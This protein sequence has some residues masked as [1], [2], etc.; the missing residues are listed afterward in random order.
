[1]K[2]IIFT[3]LSFLL[4]SS[5]TYA[6]KGIN[7]NRSYAGG[8][9][10]L[11]FLD[12]TAKNVYYGT[13]F[14]NLDNTSFS[15]L[16]GE[17]SVSINTYFRKNDRVEDYRYTILIDNTPLTVNKSIDIKELK[18]VDHAGEILR[19]TS[20][21]DFVI[22]GTAITVLIYSINNPLNIQKSVFYGKQFP[23]AKIT[24]FLKN[25]TTDKGF[26][27]SWIFDPEE[28]SD[29][30][31]TEKDLDLTL[32]KDKTDIDYLYSTS[33][34]DKQTNKIIFESTAWNYSIISEDE[35]ALLASVKIDKNVFR[36]SGDYEI[37][38]Q[39]LMNWKHCWEC[40]ISAKEIESYISRYT[41]SVTLEN[42][43]YS[44]KE[45]WTYVGL[46]CSILGILSGLTMV[47]IK[48][49]NK[50]KLAEKEQQENI[51]KLQLSSIRSQLNPHFLFNALA[52]IQNLMN[53]NEVDN[54]NKYL[55]KF[56]RLTRTVLGDKELISLS[57]EKKL[58]DDYLQMEQLRFGFKYEINQAQ[59]LDLDNVEIPSMLLQPFVEN[60]VKHGV[61][62][63]ADDGDIVVSFIR[64]ANNLVLTVADNGNGFDTDKPNKG[65]GIVLSN[66]RIALLNRIYKENHFTLAMQ[67]SDKGTKISI[68][69]TEW[70]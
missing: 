9:R 53:K 10:L 32:V 44:Q 55:T 28:K 15:Y 41:L 56:A 36:K 39:P 16:P 5:A 54:A 26:D 33:I 19:T 27:S 62:Q 60:A 30:T 2:K 46:A 24:A 69:L 1:M 70:L 8:G 42:E 40:G 47:Y 29:F 61:A 58:L 34:K 68:T 11:M 51:A 25:F 57:Q 20:L 59:D 31:F 67:S 21:G 64:Q 22:K 23:K 49:K 63:K 45:V 48:R 4:I 37:I 52:G 12:S 17:N 13:T 66:N 3:F 35:S 7:F 38:I 14:P 6:Q 65:L 50:K 43:S 18:T